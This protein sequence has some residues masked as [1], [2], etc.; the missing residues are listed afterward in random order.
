MRFSA[1][2]SKIEC[3]GTKKNS[4][5]QIYFYTKKRTKSIYIQSIYIE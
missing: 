5:V 1:L 2:F 4:H 3:K